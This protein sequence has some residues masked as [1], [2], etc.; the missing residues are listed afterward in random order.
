MPDSDSAQTDAD[1][2]TLRRGLHAHAE[3]A[4]A[5]RDTA[6]RIAAALRD[7][8]PAR[9]L[10]RV[11]GTGVVAV[12][13]GGAPGSTILLRA[14]LDALPIDESGDLPWRSR[15]A[16]VSHKCGHDGH[17]AALI[18]LAHDLARTPPERG[19]VY[20]LFQPAEETGEGAAAVLADPQFAALP[21]PDAVY[22]WH[23]I[24][25]W[26]LGRVLVKPGLFAQASTGF[27][28]RFEG[29]TSHASYPEHGRNPSRAVTALVNAVNALDCTFEGARPVLGTVTYAQL[30]ARTEGDNFGTAPGEALVTGVLRAQAT[31]DLDALCAHL[32]SLAERLAA[33]DGLGCTLSWHERF[34][35][36]TS[37]SD[38]AAIV[39]RAAAGLGMDVET[40]AEPF[41]WSEDFGCF[42][43]AYDGAFFGIGS[44]E[45]QPQL[46]DAA[47]DFPDDH[48][49]PAARLLRGIVDAHLA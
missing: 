6:A 49:A 23:N 12:F 38:G 46:H 18:A 22:A 14:E 10:E 33:S 13:E 15:T 20:L 36:T 17:M 44:G 4:H 8:S 39:A 7:C 11:G 31:A 28:V 19:S 40:L 25:K 47:N 32:G 37:S 43:D 27:A 35:A 3:L 34:A 5:E 42:T 1:P 21:P 48:I 26:P 29:A 41:R 45:Q 24:P 9:L 16:G 30:G 2:V